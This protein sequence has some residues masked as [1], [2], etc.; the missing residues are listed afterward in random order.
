MRYTINTFFLLL[1]LVS[2]SLAQPTIT[3]VSLAADNST[4]AVTF[5]ESVYSTNGG[6]GALEAADFAFS[7]SGGTATLSAANPISLAASGNVYTFVISLSG[8]PDGG[9]TLTINPVDDSIYDSA[10]NEASTT[11]TNNT[12]K[13]NDKTLPIISGVALAADNSTLAVTFSESVYSTNG[14][15]GALEVTDFVFSLS[16][17]TANLSSPTPT[18]ISASGNVYTL[19]IFLSGTAN[20]DETLTVNSASIAIYDAVG[21]AVSTTQTNN[22]VKLN[23]KTLPIIIGVA[24]A[25]DNSTLAVTFSEAVFNTNAGSDAL[26]TADFTFSISG[27]TA[28]LSSATPTSI[29]IS[30]NLYTLGIGLTGTPNGSDTLTVNP[31]DDGIYDGAGHEASTSQSN[32]FAQLNDKLPP[33]ITAVSLSKDNAILAVTFSDAVYNTSTGSGA[34]EKSDFVFSITGGQATLSSATPTSITAL[35]NVY[36]LGIGLSSTPNGDETLTVNPVDDGIYDGLGNE[37]S[38]TQS[39]N[40]VK[41]NDQSAPLI[42][43]VSVAGDNSTISVSF[44]IPAYSTNTGSGALDTADFVLS[45]SNDGTATLASSSP[46]SIAA[47]GNVYTLGIMFSESPSGGETLTV[48]P[49]LNAIFNATGNASDTTQSNNSVTLN[50]IIIPVITSVVLAAD[51]STLA[52]TFS[53][54]VY[55]TNSGSGALKAINF[56]FSISG[57][58][59]TLSS[60]T[61]TSIVASGNVY[62]LGISLIRT[63][64][65]DETLTVNPEFSAIY[66]AKGNAALT[67]QSNNFVQLND[68]LPP[69]IASVTLAEDNSTIVVTMSENVHNTSDGSGA[70]EATDFVFSLLG[71]AATLSSTTPTSIAAFET[72]YTLGIGLTGTPNGSEALTINPASSAI[73][74]T[75]GNVAITTQSNNMVM[76]NDQTIPVI[77]NVTKAN[78]TKLSATSNRRIT[79]TTSEKISD[80]KLDIQ[81]SLKDSIRYKSTGSDKTIDVDLLAPFTSGDT[82]TINLVEI[83]DMSGLITYNQTYNYI[84]DY[85]G[86]YDSNDEIGLKDLRTF[87]ENWYANDLPMELGPAIGKIPHF[88]PFLDGQYNIRDGMIFSRMWRWDRGRTGKLLARYPTQQGEALKHDVLGNHILVYTPEG[89]HGIDIRLDYPPAEI[90]LS[91]PDEPMDKTGMTLTYNDPENGRLVIHS[92]SISD[93]KNPVRINL[94]NL[95]DNEVPLNL[96]FVFQGEQQQV[97]SAGTSYMEAIPVPTEFALHK[98]YP[99]PF[100]PVTEILYDLPTDNRAQLLVYDLMGREVVQLVNE[101]LPAGYHRVAWH[102]K[103]AYGQPV[104]AGI[105]FYQLRSGSFVR[106]QKMILLK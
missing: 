91:V 64:N 79:F 46:I 14:G 45:V 75:V 19:G 29:S 5:S 71:G 30:G 40:T 58:T 61:P 103:D 93:R 59:A 66:D 9:E 83:V 101:F 31:V 52:V 67:V 104:S 17:G 33:A 82:I 43:A 27:G 63:P 13:L 36:T 8:T 85:L 96:N 60:A 50:D 54:S 97:L 42:T 20:G 49:A 78:G 89:T 65:G 68:K 105:Y 44:N 25:A 47:S 32:N 80:Y 12:V 18:S 55:S 87:V 4:L 24:L 26:E 23:D 56:T 41:L 95:V 99:N 57:G 38:T 100:N 70:L 16:G 22:T 86:D 106:T 39:N 77:T 21:N 74:D 53:E 10:G 37:A 102:A 90:E 6:S 69:T 92:A 72:Q 94:K 35:G 34:L 48:N 7:I 15:S 88:K 98:N 2:F 3:G 76:L 1:G 51:N 28:T 84:V 81:S 73:Y 62:T 11:Q